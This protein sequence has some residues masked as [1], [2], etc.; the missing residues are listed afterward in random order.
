M[1]LVLVAWLEPLL[2]T[3]PNTW[4]VTAPVWQHP[5]MPVVVL[6]RQQQVRHPPTE[7]IAVLHP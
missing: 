1:A 6:A 2:E 5:R 3:L 7:S 4:P